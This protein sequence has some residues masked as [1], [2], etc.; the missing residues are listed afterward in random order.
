MMNCDKDK[1]ERRDQKFAQTTPKDQPNFNDDGNGNLN[2]A[3]I[4]QKK[5]KLREIQKD[6][7][8]LGF[9]ALK[10]H[11]KQEVNKLLSCFNEAG[12]RGVF[13]SKEGLLRA[14]AVA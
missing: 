13:F 14:K 4:E 1:E 11:A 7:I 12:I 9:V 3:F 5:K 2:S 8:F 6:Q 10:H